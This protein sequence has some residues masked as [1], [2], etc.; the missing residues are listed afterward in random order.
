MCHCSVMLYQRSS[1]LSDYFAFSNEVYFLYTGMHQE[2]EFGGG[3]NYPDGQWGSAAHRTSKSRYVVILGVIFIVICQYRVH[4]TN[5]DCCYTLSTRYTVYRTSQLSTVYDL[6]LLYAA[7]YII[8]G[9]QCHLIYK[10]FGH[11]YKS[12]LRYSFN[13]TS[14]F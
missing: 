12:K 1:S 4:G 14:R 10:S 7:Q 5:Y 9:N 13:F 8:Q 11:T 2:T 3:T 6:L